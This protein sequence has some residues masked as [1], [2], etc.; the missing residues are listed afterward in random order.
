MADAEPHRTPAAHLDP[1]R[2]ARLRERVLSGFPE[3]S[4]V[5]DLVRPLTDMLA[6]E[7][8]VVSDVR[9]VGQ[10]VV[11]VAPGFG[12]LTGYA[13][14]DAVGRDLG[15]LLRND[16]DQ[17]AV[18]D[19]REAIRDGRAT[20]VTLRNYRADGSLF[21]CEQ[22]HHPLRDVRGR[23]GHVVTVLR[24]VTDQVN[25]RSA[26]EAARQLVDDLGGD[27]GWFAYGAL[28]DA[29]GRVQVTWVGDSCRAVLDVEP[30]TLIAG[31]L[32]E[33]VHPDDR[34]GVLERW[35]ALRVD[36]G[37]R[38]DRYRIVSADG[39]T[40]RVE[41]FAAVSWSAAEAGVVA[42]HGVVRAVA[43]DHAEAPATIDAGDVAAAFK[44]VDAGTGLPT[45]E[46]AEDRLHQAARHARRQ[47]RVVAAVAIVL[48]HFDFVHATMD[49]RRGERLVREAARRLQRALRRSDT[50]ARIDRGTFLAVLSDLEAPDAALPV[51]EKLLAWVARPFDDG[52]LRV[53]LSASAGVAVAAPHA[54]PADVFAAA[55]EAVATAQRAG[56]GRFA[57]ADPELDAAVRVRTGRERALHAAFADDQLLLHYQPRV[58]LDG[59]SVTGV[60][61]LVRWNHPTEGLLPPA[62]F[63]P[64]LERARLG[65]A[66]FE[67]VLDRATRQAAQWYRE[68]TPRRVAVNVGPEV[69]ERE[70]LARIVHRALDRASLHPGLLELEIHER[71]G[72]RTWERGAGRLRELRAMGVQV[73]L[74]DFG[75]ADTNLAQLREL[76]LD[77]LKIDRAFVARIDAGSRRSADLELLRAMIT[78]GRGLGLTV[79]AEGVE[80]ASQ[81]DHLRDLACDEAQGFLYA[82]ARPADEAFA[83]A[84]SLPN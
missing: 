36:G 40:Q 8:F 70:D 83:P 4:D 1:V 33:R 22:R 19:V 29:A 50:L 52:S 59:D 20:T 67:R 65:D 69:L 6:G 66:L 81:R 3:E 55:E 80:T 78:L 39:Q 43:A 84:T 79:V 51:V 61:G 46:V 9:R 58:R 64:D 26:E 5:E 16:T 49:P 27:G 35:R 13:P 73:A 68:G 77:T 44:D 48:D 21:W 17:D 2:L 18:R 45:R 54:R 32:M 34:A 41:D 75:A 10:P 7:T 37:S 72:R 30:A 82:P 25:A 23:T 11:H 24:D 76:P 62:A 42:L 60:E 74:D 14:A 53:E 56:G 15:F 57:F 31:G 12:D 28:V 63:L 47:G 71:T 38:R